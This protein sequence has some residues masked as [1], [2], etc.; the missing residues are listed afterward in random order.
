M[1]EADDDDLARWQ[2]A[3]LE[4]LSRGDDPEESKAELERLSM[5]MGEPH[6]AYV[7]TFEPRMIALAGRLVAK[8]GRRGPC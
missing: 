4:I 1:S 8:W 6:V 5:T 7:R 3:L 2:D